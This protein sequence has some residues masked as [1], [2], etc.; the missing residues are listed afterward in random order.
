MNWRYGAAA[1]IWAVC[2]D[3]INSTQREPTILPLPKD[4]RLRCLSDMEMPPPLQTLAVNTGA[5]AKTISRIM[6]KETG[7][8]YQQWRQQW[9]LFKAI[10]LLAEAQPISE[11]DSFLAFSSDSAFTTFFKNMT[12]STPRTYMGQR[13]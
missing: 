4:R 1:H 7:L 9:R 8:N 3:E 11:V 10:E 12:G 5:T 13:R 6:M 2:K